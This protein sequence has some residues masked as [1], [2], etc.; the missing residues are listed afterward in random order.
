MRFCVGDNGL[1]G[2]AFANDRPQQQ[3]VQRMM[4]NNHTWENNMVAANQKNAIV[5]TNNVDSIDPSK[6]VSFP[7]LMTRPTFV[8]ES[9]E[10]VKEEKSRLQDLVA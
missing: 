3:R 6:V 10:P 2:I 1:I 4:H 7:L 9:V 8:L 5:E